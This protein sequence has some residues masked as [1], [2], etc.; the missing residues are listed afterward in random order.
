MDDRFS[1]YLVQFHENIY[2][3][4]QPWIPW[5]A[6]YY[7]VD[8]KPDLSVFYDPSPDG[9]IL[10]HECIFS[11]F[12]DDKLSKTYSKTFQLLLFCDPYAVLYALI[13]LFILSPFSNKSNHWFLTSLWLSFSICKSDSS[14]NHA[15]YYFTE[16][17][18]RFQHIRD[19][20]LNSATFCRLFVYLYYIIYQ[21]I[22]IPFWNEQSGPHL[23]YIT[24][25]FYDLCIMIPPPSPGPGSR[26]ALGSQTLSLC[27]LEDWSHCWTLRSLEGS[28]SLLL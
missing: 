5:S 23:H 16:S 19:R 7:L 2:A 9:K 3:H 6:Q 21:E 8:C 13:S 17:A 20:H 25:V 4:T 27:S 12:H 15:D 24:S 10:K 1:R 28:F 18:I 22:N 11:Y 26:R 14:W